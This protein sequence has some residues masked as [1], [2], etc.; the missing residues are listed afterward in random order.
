MISNK[1]SLFGNWEIDEK[2]ISGVIENHSVKLISLD[3]FD[4]ALTRLVDSPVDAF[5]LIEQRLTAEIGTKARNFAANREIAE[6]RARERYFQT[7]GCEEIDLDAIYAELHPALGEHITRAREIEL[8]VERDLLVAVPDVLLLT[9]RL[10][11]LG[12]PFIFVSDMYLPGKFLE[13]VLSKCGY[14]GWEALYVSS[15]T[16]MTKATGR[17]WEYIAARY[18][19]LRDKILHVG[20]DT[21]SDGKKPR[22]Y[23]IHTTLF[24]RVRTERRLGPKLDPNLLPFSFLQRQ[25]VLTSQ[26]S[27]RAQSDE[28]EKWRA[29]GRVLGGIILSGFLLWLKKKVEQHNI[30]TLYFCARDGW[31]VQQ[32]WNAA[33][34]GKITGIED[35]YL[36]VS[37]RPLNLAYGYLTSSPSYL[38]R[39]FVQF[40]S[41]DGPK[42]TVRTV[43]SRAKLAKYTPIETDLI[44]HY[45]S[46]DVQLDGQNLSS[47][48]DILRKH[49]HTIYSRFR[50]DYEALV[51][52][53]RQEEVGLNGHCATVDMGWHANMQ[54]SLTAILGTRSIIGLYYGLWPA[55]TSNRFHT[56]IIESAFAS[57]FIHLEDQPEIWSAVEILEELHMPSDGTVIS[58]E[59]RNNKWAPILAN[60]SS[61]DISQ[62]ENITH[63]FQEGALEVVASL[64]T[65]GRYGSLQLDEITPK[66]V[67]ATLGAICIS[68]SASELSLLSSLRHCATFDHSYAD[69]IIPDG[70]P[71][72]EQT[73]RSLYAR[74]GWRPGTVLH[75]FQCAS[76]EQK[77]L[78]Q[79]FAQEHLK[80]LGERALRQFY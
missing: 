48:E 12:R 9:R 19:N 46:L 15:A 78:I 45:G 62:Y 54:R 18:P 1:T 34:L 55:A 35:R 57:E 53:L 37:R 80:F 40:L 58:Y 75:W 64:F 2:F 56:G 23:G 69:T 5:A 13:E 49:S 21:S 26:A 20:D 16:M 24:E 41:A 74:S 3:I 30:K 67:Q 4:T 76:S 50:E 79:A 71:K 63:P 68:P 70:F 61:L 27:L 17:V 11:E 44:E 6:R 22:E 28:R 8:E 32:A 39:A 65:S 7:Y 66:V 43:L 42:T 59:R 38:S 47:L 36:Y 33:G 52:Y 25:I 77:K 29:L 60:S 10:Q 73:M 14:A 51:G 31:L 72:D